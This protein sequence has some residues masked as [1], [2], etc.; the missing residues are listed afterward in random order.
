[1]ALSSIEQALILI[2]H[3]FDSESVYERKMR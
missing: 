1:V 3:Y 2:K